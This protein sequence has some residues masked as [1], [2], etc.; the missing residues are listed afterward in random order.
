MPAWL[1]RA[2]TAAPGTQPDP[3]ADGPADPARKLVIEGNKAW[4]AAIEVRKRWLTTEP[5]AR[6]TAP[7]EAVPFITRQLLSMPDPVRSGL[8]AA[9]GSLLFSE[10]TGH[11][12]ERWLQE[13]TWAS[14]PRAGMS[15][16]RPPPLRG[17]PTKSR[18]LAMT[19]A[20][21]GHVEILDDLVAAA[22]GTG[23]S[24]TEAA[25]TVASAARTAGL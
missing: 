3:A 7:R 14:G 12:P 6:R 5:F 2:G 25:R 16:R 18:S 20:D 19:S 22:I 8:A 21:E 4:K 9:P 1:D 24:K 13:L 15:W 23:L 17:R 11:Y 10:I